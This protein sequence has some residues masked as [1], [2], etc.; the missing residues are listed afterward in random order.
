[1]KY[2]FLLFGLFFC[3]STFACTCAIPSVEEAF[4]NSDFVYIGQIESAKLTGSNE[5]TNYLTITKEFK[6]V[7]DTDILMSE[8]S[9]SS[10]ASPS[11]VGYK[12]LV[13]GNNGSLPKLKSCSQTQVLFGAKQE[14]INKL[15]TLAI[16]LN[17]GGS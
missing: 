10:C 7:R 15:S 13:F 16:G 8:V 17:S 11:A 2:L 9:E 5:V 1:M 3:S 12:Y 4:K 6:G 14:L